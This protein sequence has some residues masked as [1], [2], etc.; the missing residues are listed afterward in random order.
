MAAGVVTS[1][2]PRSPSTQSNGRR[3][4]HGHSTSGAFGDYPPLR[5]RC[6]TGYRVH[7]TLLERGVSEHGSSWGVADAEGCWRFAP[8]GEVRTVFRD[9][10]GVPRQPGLVPEARGT[11]KLRDDPKL[12]AALQGL[13]G[14]SHVWV[15]FAFHAAGASDW[16]ARVR[17]PRLGG[18]RRVGVL[19][20]RSPHRPNPLG[21]SVCRLLAVRADAP[22]GPE[23]DLGAV[24][25]VDRSPVLDVK[26]YVPLVDAVSGALG[27]WAR[28]PIARSPVSFTRAAMADLKAHEGARPG[29]R[30]LLR[31]LLALDPRPAF[32]QRRHPAGEAASKG[33]RYGFRVLDLDVQYELTGRG[34]RV[35]SVALLEGACPGGKNT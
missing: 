15:L 11:L 32:Q 13:E 27:G 12:R 2:Q 29:L 9:R 19:A 35:I 4:A 21:L 6:R 3:T 25:L 16:R 14:F 34:F 28:E 18:A 22:G 24:D 10:F 23:L 20:S 31:G 33:R 5:I 30:G 1:E 17:A 7:G 8:I 26:P